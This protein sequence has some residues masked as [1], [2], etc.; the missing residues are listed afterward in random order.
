MGRGRPARIVLRAEKVMIWLLFLSFVVTFTPL[1]QF[2]E[3]KIRVCV[4]VL[5]VLMIAF[6]VC[7]SRPFYRAWKEVAIEAADG[8]SS[9]DLLSIVKGTKMQFYSVVVASSTAVVF[10][11]CMISNMAA[12]M[13]S[14]GNAPPGWLWPLELPQPT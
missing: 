8:G 12:S 3:W 10:F 5:V 9:E 13:M 11:L 4:L 6:A 2:W 7:A 14:G 1:P